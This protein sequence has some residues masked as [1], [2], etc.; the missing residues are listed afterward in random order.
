VP[1]CVLVAGMIVLNRR[2]LHA[3]GWSFA[4]IGVDVDARFGSL[5]IGAASGF[6]LVGLWCAVLLTAIGGE[7]LRV[8]VAPIHAMVGQ[9][10]FLVLNNLSEELAYRAYAFLVLRRLWGGTAALLITSA[11]FT[12]LHI[13]S[14]VPWQNAIM[15]VFTSALLYG[16]LF[17]RF[18]NIWLVCGTHIAMNVAQELMGIRRTA[19][20]FVAMNPPG[21]VSVLPSKT[22]LLAIAAVTVAAVAV[23]LR[24]RGPARR[25][26][27]PTARNVV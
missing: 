21:P 13:Q 11:I 24:M 15:V 9:L 1:A 8:K 5:A 19:L 20:T 10:A 3:E 4:E 16:S 14:G 17:L 27:G 2:W 22:I 18:Q 26:A 23:V 12:L 7:L 25:I 6:G